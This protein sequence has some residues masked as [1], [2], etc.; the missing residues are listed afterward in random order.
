MSTNLH[1][2]C[3]K[4]MPENENLY[5][6]CELYQTPTS[7]TYQ[8][9]YGANSER[10]QRMYGYSVR[11]S[12]GGLGGSK[13]LSEEEL[14]ELEEFENSREEIESF[15]QVMSRYANWLE[16]REYENRKEHIEEIREWIN[17]KRENGYTV[18]WGLI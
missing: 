9:L 15:H 5:D 17:R 3:F 12:F 13:V 8:I 4:K 11:K 10:L 1:L 2:T 14:K 6:Q 7:D 16:K 18:E